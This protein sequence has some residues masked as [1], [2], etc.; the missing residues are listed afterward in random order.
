MLSLDDEHDG[1]CT[2]ILPSMYKRL[3]EWESM[4][5][6]R[7][8]SS[9]S[10]VHHIKASM[11][12]GEDAQLFGIVDGATLP[13]WTHPRDTASALAGDISSTRR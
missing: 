10:F 6:Q 5:A 4:L 11:W 8:E 3:D 7:G 1:D 2:M 9:S 13:E 12:T